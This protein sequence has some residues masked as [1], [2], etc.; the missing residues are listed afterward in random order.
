[1]P[2]EMRRKCSR[3]VSEYPYSHVESDDLTGSGDLELQ[4][5]F[6]DVGVGH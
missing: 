5:D 1:M 4:E 3:P 6:E 2:L